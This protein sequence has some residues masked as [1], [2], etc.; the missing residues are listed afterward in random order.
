[1]TLDKLSSSLQDSLK[2]LLRLS[3]VDKAAV[4]E[5]TKDLQ[6]ALLQADVNVKLVLEISKRIEE[7]ALHEKIPPGV[8]RKEHIVKVL[9]DELARFLGEKPAKIPI[10]RSITNI[11]ML[12]GI[13][14]SGKTTT[15]VK[16]AR[17]LRKRGIKTALVCADTYRPGAYAQLKQLA[18]TAN[19]PVYGEEGNQDPLK[20]A[21]RGVE[22]FRKDQYYSI[23]VDTA[24]RHK[25]EANLIREM[26]SIASLIK[27]NQIMMVIDGTIGQQ[28]ITQAEA[29]HQATKIGSIAV[30]KL[31]G[32]A[33]GGGALSAVAAT[34]APITFIGTGEKIEDLE[35]F[36]PSRFAGRLL[37]M[38]DL[39]G[40]IEKVK[41]AEI[42]VPEDTTKAMLSGKITLTGLLEQLEGLRKLG[43]LGKIMKMVPGLGFDLTDSMEQ[44]SEEKMDSWKAIIH[45]MTPEERENPKKLNASRVRRIA[46]GSGCREKDVKDLVRQFEAMKKMMKSL[47]RRHHP[48]KML[49]KKM[50]REMK[51]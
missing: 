27:P 40:L 28:A 49:E 18:A 36:D 33:R 25:D 47:K 19:V 48:F 42:S 35:L 13:Q 16:L 7:R 50:L 32:S 31:D 17:F 44:L 15:S 30:A 14:G 8:S 26:R 6:R 20:I 45:S 46:R 5:L 43:P 22:L 3:V 37:G 38:G 39:R 41:E 34:G 1:M 12:I 10:E 29:F 51:T 4:K 11:I 23:I 2:S 21:K 24:G 9:Y